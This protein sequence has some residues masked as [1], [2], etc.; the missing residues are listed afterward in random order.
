MRR[1]MGL[2]CVLFV[3]A[4]GDT[5]GEDD[6]AGAMACTEAPECPERENGYTAS[7]TPCGDG[8]AG[9]REVTACGETIY[10]RSTGV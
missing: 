2:W 10:C 8:E 7:E 6:S 9:C 4:C 1:L 5:N 3:T